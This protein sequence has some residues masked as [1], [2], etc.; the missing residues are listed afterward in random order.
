MNM[1]TSTAL[2]PVPLSPPAIGP[3]E[4]AEVIATLE[5]GWLSTGPRVRRFELEFAAYAGAAHAVA[6]NSCTAGLHLAL[7]AAGIGPGDEVITTPLTFCAT[8]NVIVHA[9]ATPVFAD[10]D[11]RTGTID[12]AA[13]DAA[14]SSR[15]RAVI[16]VHYAGLPADVHTIRKLT[17]P[18]GITLIE[19]AAHCIEGIARGCKVGAIG[20]FTC[21]SFYATKN[22]TTGEGGMVTTDSAEAAAW[23]R[24]ASLHG[25]SRPAWARHRQEGPRHYDV[26]MPGFKYN[27][28]DLQAAIG[29]HQLAQIEVNHARRAAIARAYDEAFRDL[30]LG[31]FDPPAAGSLHAHHLYTVLVDD[32]A[33]VTR[34]EA[35]DR[36]AEL[37]VATSVH[38]RALH[39]QGYYRDRFGYSRGAF[40]AAERISDAVL[41]LPLSPALTDA[42]VDHVITAVRH[43][44]EA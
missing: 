32:A 21:F 5:S 26:V 13:V 35:A 34:D 41:S 6:L 37:G 40:P 7:L 12:P 10:V 33:P 24:T 42:Q 23:I 31:R 16:P 44:F 22:L 18:Q 2:D 43:V 25:I 30:P 11:P 9:G 19:D 28:T 39:L 8:A 38:F 36:L 15:T 17:R 29:L 20:D 27:M 3:E 1:K 14:L 4:I